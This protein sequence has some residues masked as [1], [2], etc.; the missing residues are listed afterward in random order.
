METPKSKSLQTMDA[1]WEQYVTWPLYSWSELSHLVDSPSAEKLGP[2]SIHQGGDGGGSL[3]L[4]PQLYLCK[5]QQ[6]K[7]L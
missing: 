7:H 2:I 4:Y 1:K 5:Y 6:L 3:N